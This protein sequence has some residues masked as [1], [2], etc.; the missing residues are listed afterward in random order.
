VNATKVPGEEQIARR[1]AARALLAKRFGNLGRNM[2]RNLDQW[3][4]VLARPPRVRVRPMGKPVMITIAFALAATVASMFLIDRAATDWAQ[5]LPSWFHVVFEQISNAGYSGWFLVPTGVVVLCVAA[6]T[7]PALPR[8]TQGVLAMLAARF[9]F[10][11]LAVAAPGLFS[12][13]IK[14]VIGRARP[15]MDV[16][17]DPFTYMPFVWRPEYASLPSGHATTVAAI[18]IAVGAVWPWTR[19]L[20]WFYA[21]VVM[22]ARVVVLAHHPSDVIA[23][24]VV[25]AVGAALVRRV[26]A[27]RRLLFSPRDLSVYPAPSVRRL[28]TAVLAAAVAPWQLRKDHLTAD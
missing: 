27:A 17:G 23:G 13:I 1:R 15:Y 4:G 2:K 25:G 19:P 21:L 16:H 18:A 12:T 20:V 8:L 22:F 6:V 28:W 3:C 26:F 10:L 11:F 14:R 9:G 5:H 7:S 24:A